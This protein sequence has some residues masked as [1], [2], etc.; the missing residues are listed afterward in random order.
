MLLSPA[1]A[2]RLLSCPR[3]ETAGHM[4]QGASLAKSSKLTW[5]LRTMELISGISR[6]DLKGD[7]VSVTG[8][9]PAGAEGAVSPVLWSLCPRR[10]DVL[11]KNPE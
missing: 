7:P 3:R 10:L 4:T 2:T 6:L 5:G 11:Q 1:P 9:G 8:R